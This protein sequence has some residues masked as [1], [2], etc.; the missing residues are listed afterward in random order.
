MMSLVEEEATALTPRPLQTADQEGV[1]GVGP[2]KI[3]MD[4]LQIIYS[5]KSPLSICY[6]YITLSVH[7]CVYLYV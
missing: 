5:W 6:L 3:D 2:Q 1:L 7:L 4:D